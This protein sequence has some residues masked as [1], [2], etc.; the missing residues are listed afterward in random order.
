MSLNRLKF[1]S[2]NSKW[3]KNDVLVLF[4]E[5]FQ[6]GYANGLVDEALQQGLK[7][8]YATVGRREK[9]GELRALLAEEIPK[10]VIF[11]NIPLEAGF[12]LEPD[13]QGVSCVDELKDVKLSEWENFQ[14]DPARFSER[15]KN[16][17]K[18][19]RE[20]TQKFISEV[21]KLV[22]AGSNVLFAH[23]MAGGVP[24]TK[25]VMPLMNRAVKGVGDRYLPSEKFWNSGIGKLC[26]ENFYEVTAETFQ[27][28]VEVSEDFRNKKTQAGL[29]VSYLAYGYHGTEIWLNEAFRWQTYTPYLQGWAKLRLEKY[30]ENAKD[31]GISACIYNCPEI[32]T[33]SSSIFQ[34]LELSI[35]PLLEAFA[36]LKPHAEI[37]KKLLQ[38]ADSVFKDSDY[39]KIISRRINQYF[40][41]PSIL[42]KCDFDH[43]PSHSSQ[44][45]LEVMLTETDELIQL[46]KDPKIGITAD[47]SECVFRGCGKIMFQD[48]F[49]PQFSVGW[50]GHDAIIA[51]QI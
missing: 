50:I 15:K 46:Q 35:Y 2:E 43:W 45:Q 42:K 13:S 33:N 1:I 34:G 40:S 19:F 26:Q 14:F 4:G 10:D 29:N 8:I 9:T 32:H 38:K 30:S 36:L 3:K 31:S 16:G 44:E 39:L 41:H 11:I 48:S 51:S 24:R 17:R 47:L 12:D 37:S 27:T 21:E 7:V 6:R 28:L 20:Q 23:L 5:L 18:R 49:K 25:I 22:P